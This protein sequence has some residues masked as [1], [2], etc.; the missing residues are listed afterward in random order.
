MLA[1]GATLVQLT[2]PVPMFAPALLANT[3]Q[4]LINL[5]TPALLTASHALK[6]L[7]Y[8]RHASTI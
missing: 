7:G 8:A 2:T 6:T 1:H 4:A 5:A 3:V